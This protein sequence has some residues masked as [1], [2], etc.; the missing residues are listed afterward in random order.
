MLKSN[1]ALRLKK[2]KNHVNKYKDADPTDLIFIDEMG[3]HLNMTLDY[4]RAKSGQRIAMPKPFVRGTKISVI[5][6]VSAAGV[7]AALYGEWA[8]ATDIFYH[9]IKNDLCPK[10]KANNIVLLDNVSF[11]KN[12]LIE[13]AISATGAKI[14]F[15]PPYSPHFNPI[16]MGWSFVK[17]ILCEMEA[18]TLRSSQKALKFAL[19]QISAKQL[20]AWFQHAGYQSTL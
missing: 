2:R 14:D 15:L 20:M 19:G 7:E 9:F 8:T 4:A 16:E 6:A 10:L 5:G 17:N 3:A 13:E 11:H 1:Y 12:A 18:R